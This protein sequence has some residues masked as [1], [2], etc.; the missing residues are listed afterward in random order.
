MMVMGVIDQHNLNVPF[1]SG[2]YNSI[3]SKKPPQSKNTQKC[4]ES[5]F[6]TMLILCKMNT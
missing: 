4:W 1:L 6:R 5:Q 3:T 2:C